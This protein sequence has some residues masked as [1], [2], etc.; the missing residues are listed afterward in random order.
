MTPERKQR[1][2]QVLDKRQPDLTV[3]LENVFDPHNIAA[4]LRTCD[5]VGIVEAFAITDRIPH[6]KAWGF[7]SSRSASKWVKLHYFEDRETCLTQIRARYD[8]VLGAAIGADIPS[9]YDAN[10]TGS[11]ALVFGNEKYG[12]SPEMME[13][14]D[15]SFHI[16]QQGMI[17]SLNI[18]VACAVTIYE[19]MRQR[20]LA[21]MYERPSLH[22][23]DRRRMFLEWSSNQDMETSV[24]GD[25]DLT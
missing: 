24:T 6:R 7:R 9:I 15:G 11:A 25:Q 13:A 17:H 8:R 21:G 5:A 14:C 22:E 1:I 23:T 3:L 16:P 20:S 18:S 10:F 2:D 4:V 19:A 12:L